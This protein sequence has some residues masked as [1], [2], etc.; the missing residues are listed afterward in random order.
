[1][2]LLRPLGAKRSPRKLLKPDGLTNNAMAKADPTNA[3]TIIEQQL[4]GHVENLQKKL[5]GDVLFY[6]GPILYGGDDLIRDA[7][8]E[9]DHKKQK[10]V[11]LLETTGGYIEWPKE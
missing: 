5:D 3:N 1:M 7:L 11:V 6:C 9:M 2:K 4:D 8:E 10:L